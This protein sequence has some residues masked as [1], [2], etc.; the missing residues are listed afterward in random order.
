MA[1][2]WEAREQRSR[3][4]EFCHRHTAAF[5]EKRPW[6]RHN[7]QISPKI[8]AAFT[9]LLPDCSLLTAATFGV[10]SM[11]DEIRES[12]EAKRMFGKISTAIAAGPSSCQHAMPSLAHQ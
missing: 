10:R 1:F 9:K 5:E 6:S 3:I 8:H 11:A 2:I 12:R 4:W 7:L